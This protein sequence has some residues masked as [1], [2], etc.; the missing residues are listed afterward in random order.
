MRNNKHPAIGEMPREI[1]DRVSFQDINRSVHDELA[2]M[3][4]QPT[5]PSETVVHSPPCACWER[6][7]QL[8]DIMKLVQTVLDDF[9]SGNSC[10]TDQPSLTSKEHSVIGE[11]KAQL[12]CIQS[13]Y[14]LWTLCNQIPS[15]TPEEN[16]ILHASTSQESLNVSSNDFS[17]KSINL[18]ANPS[19]PPELSDRP[20]F[21]RLRKTHPPRVLIH[22][23]DAEER[24]QTR[25]PW[26]V[27]ESIALWYGV[28]Y[29]PGT[30]SWSSI[31]RQSFR[32]S[33]RTQVNLKDRWRV[34]QRNVVVRNAVCHAFLS[35]K[36][37]LLNRPERSASDTNLPIP[38]IVRSMVK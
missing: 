28:H 31:W 33:G 23:H 12:T 16:I 27:E 9:R 36:L 7:F 4:L 19:D 6:A 29:Y 18:P 21:K 24:G 1:L 26:S 20:L 17:V 38:V 2:N 30:A 35:W 32:R 15:L 25:L 22:L 5:N 34:I 8:S 37:E 3:N 11:L 10:S 14:F 13:L